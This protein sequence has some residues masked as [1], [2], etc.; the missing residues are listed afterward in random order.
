MGAMRMDRR[1]FP[2]MRS[3][4]LPLAAAIGICLATGAARAGSVFM[5]NGYIIQGPVLEYSEGTDGAVVL[6]W[7][8]G[9]MTIY[10]RFIEKLD[11]EPGEEKNVKVA[12]AKGG[13]QDDLLVKSAIEEDLPANLSD[14]VVKLGL[15]PALVEGGAKPPPVKN[16]G[17]PEGAAEKPPVAGG[18][19]S[20]VT[21]DDSGKSA[22]PGGAELATDVNVVKPPEGLTLASRATAPGWGFSL[23]PPNGWRQEEAEGC[24]SWTGPPG[25][26]GFSPSLNV[27]SAARGALSWEEACRALRDEVAAG[28]KGRQVTTDDK[29]LLKGHPAY[30]VS[31]RGKAGDSASAKDRGLT[32]QQ[33]LVE[34][35]GRLWL[36]STF[37]N[38]TDGEALARGLDQALRTFQLE[39]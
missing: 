29:F 28:L 22:G 20:R 21:P 13:D 12:E 37:L 39:G 34:R 7:A 26:D 19:S 3:A 5:K 36:I 17:Q 24:I 27:V 1:T 32:V 25:P 15:P 10:H 31:A 9:K 35:A 33:V 30:R 6:G 11:L 38:E 23:E 18:D 2:A 8:N 4:A 16:D 14:F